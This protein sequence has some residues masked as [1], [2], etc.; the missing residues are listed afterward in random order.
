MQNKRL[1]LFLLKNTVMSL[2]GSAVIMAVLA[3]L[4]VQF[5]LLGNFTF[6]TIKQ[7]SDIP[8]LYNSGISNVEMAFDKL[9]YMGYDY[10]MDGKRVGGYYCAWINDK[11]MIVLI[12]DTETV[13]RDY[14]V[15]GQLK[16]DPATCSYIL[17][18]CAESAG[19]SKEQLEKVTYDYMISEIDYPKTFYGI[20]KL[21]FYLALAMM[22]L[23]LVEI[24]CCIFCPWYH[25]RIRHLHG[26]FDR[27][28]VVRDINRQ[29]HD[30][31]VYESHNCYV[32]KKYLIISTLF[33]TD[34]VLLRNIEVISK[35][36]ER[37]GRAGHNIYK[38]IIS[39]AAGMIYEH[40]FKSESIVDEIIPLIQKKNTR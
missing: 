17:S 38:L 12:D 15:Q 14:T 31:V 30:A 19:I 26:V 6:H 10:C 25:P 32:T 13:I 9:Q 37:K 40:N 18:Q 16:K 2:L 20:V 27:K 34:I 33:R 5:H 11:F 24:V 29:L 7:L 22:A 23:S 4:M 21:A 35:H 36:T 28:L 3:G 8:G 39:N 1:N